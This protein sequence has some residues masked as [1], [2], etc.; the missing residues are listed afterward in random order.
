MRKTNRRAFLRETAAGLAAAGL[1]LPACNRQPVI[2]VKEIPDR[3]ILLTLDTLRADHLPCFGYP[4]GTAP[5]LS[6]LA[7]QSVVFDDL[8]CACSNTTPS[9]TSI[10]TGLHPAQHNMFHNNHASLTPGLFTMAE[11]FQSLGHDTAAFCAVVWMKFF[12]QG[13]RHFDT[14]GEEYVQ[15]DGEQRHYRR[16]PEV[17]NLALKWL[18]DKGPDDKFFLWLHLYD[19]HDPYYP[20]ED[21]RARMAL[22]SAE[23][24]RRMMAYWQDTQHK[25]VA[26]FNGDENY[27]RH[28]H[29]EYD[30][31][32]L[33]MDREIER[34]YRH[35]ESAG[36]NR[37]TVWLMT[38]DHGEGL[39]NHDYVGHGQHIY[40]EQIRC[41]TLVHAADGRFPA[42]Q[43]AAPVQHVDLL[44]TLAALYG[45]SLERQTMTVQ[46]AS[47]L[48]M[49]HGEDGALGNRLRFVQRRHK[50]ES[51]THTHGWPEDPVYAALDSGCKFIHG[52]RPGGE[53]Y[54]LRRDPFEL[55]NLVAAEL[56]PERAEIRDRLRVAA[57][58]T[59]A[60]LRAEG[61]G[62]GE[63]GIST[64]HEEALRN[65]GYL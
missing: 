38:A 16:A 32:I 48:P 59:F 41:M 4:R 1:A 14:F 22:G 29:T 40:Q 62:A 10:F 37:N 19:P 43:V 28:V 42:R 7:E 9:H 54:D 55:E 64:E 17:V 23:E 3:C 2:P 58:A 26:G 21:A 35:C 31:E 51:A 8:C 25:R 6:R 60:Q 5:F 63:T 46:G 39:G 15:G 53:F 65:L 50:L 45:G 27:L 18:K 33:H 44:P 13:F 47:L 34:L 36:L 49:L 57:D 61:A 11:M 24:T 12:E 30:A 20:S 56:D 52:Q